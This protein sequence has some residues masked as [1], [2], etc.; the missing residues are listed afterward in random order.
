M[1]DVQGKVAGGPVFVIGSPRSGTTWL[2]EMLGAHHCVCAPPEM[3][4][5]H[6]YLSRWEASW[7]RETEEIRRP[8]SR[9]RGLPSVLDRDGFV[10]LLRST[11]VAAYEMAGLDKPDATVLLD[12]E[13]TNTLHTALISEVFPEARFIHL[14][15]DGRDVAASLLAANRGWARDWAP[16]N[17]ADAARTWRH[18]VE[19]A[20]AARFTARCYLEVRYE[21]L[22]SCPV[23][24]LQALFRFVGLDAEDG[25]AASIAD[26]FSFDRI[27]DKPTEPPGFYR[28]GKVGSWSEEWSAYDR[29]A[30]DRVAGALLIETGYEV[31]RRWCSPTPGAQ[32][33]AHL[34]DTVYELKEGIKRPLRGWIARHPSLA[35]E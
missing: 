34:T 28:K 33:A 14:L 35:T 3:G 27:K 25:T 23:E 11:A 16:D 31:D 8:D 12:K 15:R 1:S 10:A 30:F 9:R 29:A 26:Q 18:H 19:L 6:T 20:R 7:K 4:L 21:D 32:F 17:T 24:S 13:P 22:L 2:Q 5:F